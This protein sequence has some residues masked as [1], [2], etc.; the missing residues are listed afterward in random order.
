[1]KCF[2][3]VFLLLS[4][5]CMA[6]YPPKANVAIIETDSLSGIF[7]FDLCVDVLESEGYPLNRTDYSSLTLQTEP[8]E[9]H[10]LPLFFNLEIH[11]KGALASIQGYIKDGRDF[12]RKGFPAISKKWEEAANRSF[13]GSTWRTGFEVVI[14]VAEKIRSSTIGKVHWDRLE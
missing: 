14:D 4:F 10:D 12:T 5:S 9:I 7:L 13:S 6:Q 2:L 3:T 8:V 11:V 1:M